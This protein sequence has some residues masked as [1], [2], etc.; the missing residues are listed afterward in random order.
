MVIIGLY[1]VAIKFIAESR[2][3]MS[4]QEKCLIQYL[5]IYLIDMFLKNESVLKSSPYKSSH[6]SIHVFFL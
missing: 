2:I 5:L 1:I 3:A 4:L 6:K